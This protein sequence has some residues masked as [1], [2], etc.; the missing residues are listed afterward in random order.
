MKRIWLILIINIF[1][2]FDSEVS[3][4]TDDTTDVPEGGSRQVSMRMSNMGGQPEN[5][6]ALIRDILQAFVGVVNAQ[7]SR[8]VPVYVP[9]QYMTHLP[10]QV[11]PAPG[12]QVRRLKLR[13]R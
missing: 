10:H 12:Q 4:I 9:P 2:I 7:G 3:N 13:Q 6:G 1:M 8:Q 11:A 5:N